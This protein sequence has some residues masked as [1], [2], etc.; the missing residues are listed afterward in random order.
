MKDVVTD[1]TRVQPRTPVF[2]SKIERLLDA[3]ADGGHSEF[4]FS[5]RG[6]DDYVDFIA[7]RDTAHDRDLCFCSVRHYERVMLEL[8][9][10]LDFGVGEVAREDTRVTFRQ[11]G[12]MEI[13]LAE[14][15]QREVEM[16]GTRMCGRVI[17]LDQTAVYST[18]FVPIVSAGQRRRRGR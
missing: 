1:D 16:S 15:D 13:V 18:R 7:I 10:H 3:V 2:N 14:V 5:V 11:H 17:T 9:N 4:R 8:I 6:H 12:Q